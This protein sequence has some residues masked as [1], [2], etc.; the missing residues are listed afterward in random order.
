MNVERLH[1]AQQ[2]NKSRLCYRELGGGVQLM[3]P[4]DTLGRKRQDQGEGA[5]RERVLLRDPAVTFIADDR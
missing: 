4:R 5:F 2:E 3:G 1:G